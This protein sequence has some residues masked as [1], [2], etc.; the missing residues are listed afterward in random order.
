MQELPIDFINEVKV[1]SLMSI[2]DLLHEGSEEYDFHEVDFYILVNDPNTGEVLPNIKSTINLKSKDSPFHKLELTSD[3]R[4]RGYAMTETYFE[5]HFSK[6]RSLIV[7]IDYI[8]RVELST[9]YYK[10]LIKFNFR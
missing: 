3:P 9:P 10:D 2:I 7:P 8:S 4:I 6:N 5:V 1:A